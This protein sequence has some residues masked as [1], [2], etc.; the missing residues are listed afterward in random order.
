MYLIR[1]V[2]AADDTARGRGALGDYYS[3]KG[4]TPG[5]W[6]GSGLAAL[7]QPRGLAAIAGA[8]PWTV[9]AGSEVNETQMKALFGL[10]THPNQDAIIAALTAEGTPQREAEKSARLG[11]KF[12]VYSDDGNAFRTRLKRAYEAYNRD[13]EQPAWSPIGEATRATI[14]TAVATEVFTE[15]YN[16]APRDAR[17][18]SGFIARNTRAATTAVAGYD[19]TFTPVKSISTVWA[20][21]PRALSEAIEAAHHRAVTETLQWA[22]ENLAFSRMGTNGVAQVETTG[23]IAAAFDH[24][25][26]RAGDPN[27]HTHVVVSNKVC[28][29][30]ADGIPRWLA[31]DG[32]MLYRNKVVLSEQ[33]NTRMERNCVALGFRYKDTA[34]AAGRRSVREI[35]GVPAELLGAYSSRRTAIEDRVG[36]LATAFQTQHGREPTA[37]EFITLSQ[38]ATL[39]SRQAKHAPRSLADQRREWRR[40]AVQVLGSAQDIDAMI[41]IA[42]GHTHKPAALTDEMVASLAAKVIATVSSE[43]ATWRANH[44]RAEAERQLRGNAC[45]GDPQHAADRIVAVAL[46][47]LSV[48]ISSHLDEERNEPAF[49]RRS[50]GASVYR[51]HHST[52]YTSSDVLAAE[53]RILAAAAL[54]G[55]RVAD[56][57]SIGLALLE[58]HA[59]GRTLNDGQQALVREMAA[60]GAR[61]QLAL[62]PAGTGKTTAMSAL[63][64]AWRNSGGTV[65]GLAPT[66]GAAEVLA[67]DLGT[68]ADTIAKLVQLAD[69]DPRYPV[70]A[71]DPA[72]QWFD[73]ID[74]ST[75][76]LVDEA[77]KASTAELDAVRAVAL[78]RGASIRLVG[79]DY[80]LSS[81]SAG[82]VLRDIAARHD[83]LT[84]SEV[85]RFGDTDRG[86]AEGAASLA[87]RR[88]DPTGI[89]FYLD[90]DRIHVGAD[91]TAADL[92]YTAWVADLLAER[93]SILLAPTNPLVAELNE[94]ARADRLRLFPA[95]QVGPTVTLGDT[96]TASA[97]DWITTRENARWLRTGERTW[98]KNGHRWV[99][100]EVNDDGSLMVSPLHGDTNDVLRL[101]A[102]Y[103]KSHTTL[104]YASTIDVR[105]GSTADTCH[106]VG[107]DQLNRQQLYVALTRGRHQNHLYFSTSEA[108]PHQ[109][110]TSK[111]IHPPT[112]ADILAAILR[113]DDR[114]LSAHTEI[115]NEHDPTLRLGR[116]AAMYTDALHTAAAVHAGTET[117]RTIDAAA[118][119]LALGLHECGGWPV[120]RRHLALLA[121]DGHDPTEALGH[122]AARG[123]LSDANDPAAVLDWRLP[124][125]SGGQGPGHGPLQWLDPIPAALAEGETGQYL[126]ARADLVAEL[127]DH[128]RGIAGTW[129]ASTV[130]AWGRALMQHRRLLAEVA[131]FR[132]SHSVDPAD[133]RITGPN[134][135]ATRAAMTQKAILK[136]LDAAIQA[137]DMGA[138]RW[139]DAAEAHDR[140]IT[141]DPY[142]PQLAAHLDD[143]ARAGADI[144]TLLAEAMERGGPLPDEL[145]AAALWWRLAGSLSPA[146]LDSANSR[147]R[148]DWTA[149]LHR[150]LGSRIAETV[151]ADPAWPSLVAA[152]AASDWQP[153]D[154]LQA[155]AEHMHDLAAVGD[156]RPDQI[157]RLLAYRVELLTQGASS[158]FRDV[159][160]PGAEPSER[161]SG[162]GVDLTAEPPEDHLYEPPPDPY[163]LDYGYADEDLGGL[164][165]TD[166]PRARPTP[167]T[168]EGD[169]TELRQR[170]AA[171]RQQVA[172]LTEAI[173]C[174]GGGPAET[175]ARGELIALHR[176]HSEQRPHQHALA[177]AHAD[178]VAAEQARDT[179][180]GL[181]TQLTGQLTAAEA[182]G[183]SDL[184]D[185]FR[186]DLTER[187][188]RTAAIDAAAE[189]ARADRDCAHNA[190]LAIAGGPEGIVTDEDIDERRRAA[191]AADIAALQHARIQARDLD[192][193]IRR[194]EAAAARA[195]ATRAAGA[196]DL[197]RELTQMRDEIELV[198]SAGLRS[199]ATVYADPR[200]TTVADLSEPARSAVS[201]II[202]SDM[203]VQPLHAHDTSEKNAVIRAVALTAHHNDDKVLAIPASPAAA[204][205]ARTRRYA[206]ATAT[207]GEAI[208]NLTTGVWKPPPGSLLIVDDADHLDPDQLRRLTTHAGATNTKLLLATND[209]GTPGPSHTLTTAL[210]DTLPW[211]QHLGTAPRRPNP[212]T[213]LARVAGYIS[214]LSE[215]PQDDP[216]REAAA[217]LTRRDN[218]AGV[219]RN[220]AAP[221]TARSAALDGPSREPGLSI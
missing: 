167:S 21:S 177:H 10:G 45:Y 104:G 15:Q 158:V 141:G 110:L 163:D 31:L 134:Q 217:L 99:I 144:K 5:R 202:D 146:T 169:L 213:A 56:D 22:E 122:A 57:T 67:A 51:Q 185:R 76:I 218:L 95:E 41:A 7:S 6:M 172:A 101:P 9:A 200:E 194:V 190:L 135:F 175:A 210:A 60:S 118:D 35:D 64:T 145:P 111:A 83:A 143:A 142:W 123:D 196:I 46:G 86:K 119:A 65:V 157:C 154:L 74:H 156:V 152:V 33:Y 59:Q 188:Q 55:G 8:D 26:S 140:R 208:N 54:G 23:L 84:L 181:L 165:F 219:Y 160:H 186:A 108:D 121:V 38:T 81:V 103:V 43:R 19:L 120:L 125:V 13:A 96:L 133:T 117:M 32:Q 48:Q 211:S 62:A 204:E 113:R 183:D 66:A 50:D 128:V 52:V 206:H 29:I 40:Q 215:V 44:V 139:R 97:G 93:D 3:S 70:V 73:R 170:R 192:N 199:P 173:F 105:Q 151:I 4:E 214:T 11:A 189:T 79:D 162:D 42:S 102:P 75:L 115:A 100:R 174:L 37:V 61:V 198:E 203:A 107:G 68:E 205:Q 132:A 116:A 176:R 195:F 12:R 17:E 124:A 127:A 2:A 27:L 25:D 161:S 221:V 88:G 191:A 92:A 150:I 94:R 207:P 216:H 147:L 180:H 171:A 164:D 71:D 212:G 14:R 82:G 69:P 126:R 16:R 24:R 1:Q 149:D 34:T 130:P 80:Q 129:T 98:V 197:S 178:W 87:L 187:A 179:H 53:R 47:D 85:V 209:T 90:H 91:A 106:V 148:P 20:L 159:P 109:I 18:L 39:E 63:A 30:G 78:A 112:A 114:Q 153:V 166:L 28:V 138:A 77:G 182:N 72:R 137:T 49:L 184:A 36:E 168:L 136:R 193:H 89:G 220:L 201:H 131:V 58:A 155:A